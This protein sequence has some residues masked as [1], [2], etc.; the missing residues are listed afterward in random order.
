[1]IARHR[2]IGWRRLAV[3]IA[4]GLLP[5]IAAIGFLAWYNWARFGGILDNGLDYHHMASIFVEDYHRYGPFNLHYLPTN[6]FYQ[7]IT[8]PLPLRNTTFYG[9]SMFLLTPVFF[10]AWVG[11][12]VMRPRWSMWA[13]VVSI[14][15]VSIPILLLMGTGWVQFGPRYTLDFTV[16]LL[17]LTAAGL[18]R[19]PLKVLW[20]LTIVSVVPY[21]LG[22]YYLMDY[23]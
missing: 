5:V 7:Y 23:M 9:G 4:A 20:L 8:Y 19:C 21:L 12:F 16:P 11:G 13:L 6:L 15:L 10:A 14:V 22:T 17:L 2:S 1:L 18:R 3:N